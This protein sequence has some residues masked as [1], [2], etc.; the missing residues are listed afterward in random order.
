MRHI[1]VSGVLK[2]IGAVGAV[3]ALLTLG[4]C[5][6]SKFEKSLLKGCAEGGNSNKT[7]HCAADKLGETYDLNN[8]EDF[9]ERKGMPIQTL[10]HDYAKALQYCIDKHGR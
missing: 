8:I 7:C 6:G 1:A 10:T 4:A 5:S 2:N 3:C 9:M